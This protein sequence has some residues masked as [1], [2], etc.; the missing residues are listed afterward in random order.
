[1]GGN[2]HFELKWGAR[3]QTEDYLKVV[4]AKFSGVSY[5]EQQYEKFISLCP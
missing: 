4:C 1:V 3:Y 5:V 2:L